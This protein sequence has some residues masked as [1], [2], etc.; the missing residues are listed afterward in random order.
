VASVAS[1]QRTETVAEREELESGLFLNYGSPESLA[2]Q[3]L[4][5]WRT[6][7]LLMAGRLRSITGDYP[8]GRVLAV[9]GHAHKGPLEAALATDQWDLEIADIAELEAFA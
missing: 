1:A 7:K 6:R 4:A 5:G 8:G 9:V 2:R 3:A